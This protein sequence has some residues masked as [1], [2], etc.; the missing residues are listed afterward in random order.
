MLDI[1]LN[2]MH[3][4]KPTRKDS[5]LFK[6]SYFTDLTV[7]ATCSIQLMIIILITLHLPRQNHEAPVRRRRH[8]L[9]C[10]LFKSDV[11][12]GPRPRT[13]SYDP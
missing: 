12:G 13:Y 1:D 10:K 7:T 4:Y 5:I 11:A 3:P 6:L 9:G 8:A 2:A